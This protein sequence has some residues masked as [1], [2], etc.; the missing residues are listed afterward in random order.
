MWWA[1]RACIWACTEPATQAGLNP[2]WGRIVVEMKKKPGIHILA[3][4]GLGI[5]LVAML[6]MQS[7]LN[8]AGPNDAALLFNA[9]L[10][11][12]FTL[13][14]AG[15]VLLACNKSWG[16]IVG[17]A[18]S[19]VFVPLGL[20]CMAGCL[21]SR[22]ALRYA[23][24]RPADPAREGEEPSAAY[25]FADYRLL[26]ALMLTAGL[27]IAAYM[28]SQLGRG[29]SS[30]MILAVAGLIMLLWN[31]RQLR[32]KVLA[33][34][35]D[36]LECVPGLWAQPI[37]VPYADIRQAGLRANAGLILV[38]GPAGEDRIR[39]MFAAMPRNMRNA[40]GAAFRAKMA[41]LGVPR[42]A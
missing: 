25:D 38:D 17:V 4:I 32:W 6:A 42:E 20:V 9:L 19:V 31:Q 5:N 40:A 30:G 37:A 12:S 8:A 11:L 24:Y 35:S 3:K 27:L 33:L 2:A 1:M 16:G 23:A 36:H 13:S 41:E 22:S 26:Y 21:I 7:H 39:I 34:Y 10:L 28:H 15:M 29:A 18:G 14:L